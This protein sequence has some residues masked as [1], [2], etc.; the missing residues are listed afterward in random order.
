M[1]DTDRLNEF[2]LNPLAILAAEGWG[3]DAIE[4]DSDAEE[5]KFV[6]SSA[7]EPSDPIRDDVD[8]G[9]DDGATEPSPSLDEYEPSWVDNE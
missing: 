5:V 6:Y 8:T 7:V 4:I 1:A 9:E 3:P 2:A